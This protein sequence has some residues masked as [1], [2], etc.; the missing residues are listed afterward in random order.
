MDDVLKLIKNLKVAYDRELRYRL[1]SKYPH[2]LTKKAIDELVK[3]KKIIKTNLPGRRGAGSMPNVFYRLPGTPYT[4]QLKAIMKKKL[5]LSIFINEI[6]RHMG[7]IAEVGWWRAFKDNKWKVIPDLEDHIGKGI[8]EYK[9]KKATIN[10]DID[11]IA[12]KDGIEYGVEIKNGLTYPDDLFW[13]ITVAL[14]LG[15]IPI[16]IARWLNPA[17]V[18][19]F[20]KINIPFVVFKDAMYSKTYESIIKEIRETLGMPIEAREI[21]DNDFFSKKIDSI[22]EN[23][24]QNYKRIKQK[25][26]HLRYELLT[27]VKIRKIL[28]DKRG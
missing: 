28:G 20:K 14:D 21:V 11:F 17:Q 27:D 25:L 6:S 13:K 16:V 12:I 1:E 10:N 2:D 4:D 7:H 19:L 15:I 23:I 18:N 9:G 22:H 3:R 5:E 26:K 8:N 24:K